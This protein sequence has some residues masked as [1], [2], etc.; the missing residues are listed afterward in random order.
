M[1]T[2]HRRDWKGIAGRENTRVV[3][4]DILCFSCGEWCGWLNIRINF[5]VELIKI[6]NAIFGNTLTEQIIYWL[7]ICVYINIQTYEFSIWNPRTSMRGKCVVKYECNIRAPPLYRTHFQ[8]TN[9]LKSCLKH[10]WGFY[11]QFIW[12]RS[13]QSK[14]SRLAPGN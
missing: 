12:L 14:S 1:M 4:S 9:H 7:G 6:N 2:I 11:L 3:R 13:G 10:F 5:E 8:F